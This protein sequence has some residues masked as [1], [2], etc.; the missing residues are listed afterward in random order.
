VHGKWSN[1]ADGAALAALSAD[2]ALFVGDIG[3]EDADLVREIAALGHPKAVI[4]GCVRVCVCFARVL[5]L[6]A[7]TQ[8]VRV[9]V[10]KEGPLF[11][12][13]PPFFWHRQKQSATHPNNRKPRAATTTR[14]T[15]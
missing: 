10:D 13:L 12:T 14:G 9:C 11:V 4:L 6:Q 2:F 8:C 7:R 3:N 5:L 1:G 15:R